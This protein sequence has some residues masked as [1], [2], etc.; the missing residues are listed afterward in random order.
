[1]S[2]TVSEVS[3]YIDDQSFE[4]LYDRYC[5][6][7]YSIALRIVRN[8]A[9]AE[10]V[11]HEVFVLVWRHASRFDPSRGTF[12]AW[13]TTLSRNKALDQLRL[14]CER[15]RLREDQEETDLS[16]WLPSY[17]TS[18]DVHR[19][20][21]SVRAV[22]HRLGAGQRTAIELAFFEGLTHEEI[23]Q[24]LTTPLGT[25]KSWIRSGLLRMKKEL[26]SQSTMDDPRTVRRPQP[27]SEF[28]L[29]GQL[30]AD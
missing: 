20:M 11:T 13:I 9:T 1:V 27:Q 17:E 15:Q 14:K 26:L 21:E 3:I 19:Q 4:E 23:A 10:E 29:S 24:R 28:H 12:I 8:T 5:R 6:I 16:A 18:I 22:L 25:V 2:L 30:T 7:V